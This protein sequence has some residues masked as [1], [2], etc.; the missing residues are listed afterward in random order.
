[1]DYEVALFIDEAKKRNTK[2]DSGLLTQFHNKTIIRNYFA[3]TGTSDVERSI[4][5]IIE[6]AKKNDFDSELE[7]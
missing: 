6:H 2:V 5:Y 7:L 4:K 1:M 3:L